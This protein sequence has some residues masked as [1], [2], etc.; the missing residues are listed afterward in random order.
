MSG[1]SALIQPN[2]ALGVFLHAI[3]GLMA[4]SFYVPLKKVKVWNWE[5]FWLVQGVAAWVIMPILMAYVTIPNIG[6]VLSAGMGMRAALWAYLFGALWGIGGLTFGLS[7]R[8]LGVSLGYALALGFCAAF[9]TMLPP[10]ATGHAAKLFGSL[11]GWVTVGGVAVC[12]AGIAVC[13]FAGTL[14]EKE[15]TAEQ[16]REAIR[17]FALTKGVAVAIFAGI[18]SACMAFAMTAGGPIAEY[19]AQHGA[20][21]IFKNNAVL[22]FVLAGGFTTNLIWCL[23]LNVVNR[24]GGDYLK[25]PV[26]VNL[27]LCALGGATWYLQFFFY[28]MGTTKMGEF[29]FASWTIH[30]AFII[31]F[32]NVWALFLREWKGSSKK[33][34]SLVY[35]GIG[36]L[37]LSTVVVGLGTYLGKP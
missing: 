22:V 21:D 15:M 1:A 33:T 31:A 19:A 36:V 6:D 25:G 3:G 37:V 23:I 26:L 4:A 16:K 28:G 5:S 11:S 9:G 32:S 30:M 17:E 18:M 8:Y 34:L 13:C 7:M 35:A 10:L 27:G 29:N 12:L 24:T 2:P 20:M 14:K